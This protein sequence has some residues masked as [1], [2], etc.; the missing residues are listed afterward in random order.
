MDDVI[1]GMVGLLVSGIAL[2]S[3]FLTVIAANPDK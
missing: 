2:A 1:I 3:L